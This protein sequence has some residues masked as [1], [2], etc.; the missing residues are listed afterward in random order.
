MLD[1]RH[2]APD[3]FMLAYAR[4]AT[5]YA[6]ALHTIVGADPSYRGREAVL[7]FFRNELLHHRPVLRRGRV[8]RN[9]FM[10]CFRLSFY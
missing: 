6:C 9:N 2:S 1:P 3:E 4:S 10:L 5:F 7:H 8:L